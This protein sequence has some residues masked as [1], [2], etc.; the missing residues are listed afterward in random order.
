MYNSIFLNFCDVFGGTIVY[1]FFQ[2]HLPVLSSVGIGMRSF[3]SN[4]PRSKLKAKFAVRTEYTFVIN[5]AVVSETYQRGVCISAYAR[6]SL[7]SAW[8]VA[9]S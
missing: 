9:W 8:I 7:E 4:S 3:L 6:V 1:I 2:S 5:Q